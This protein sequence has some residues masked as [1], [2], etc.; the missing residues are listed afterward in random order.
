MPVHDRVVAEAQIFAVKF[1]PTNPE[2]P[3]GIRHRFMPLARAHRV[4]G[5]EPVNRTEPRA[6]DDGEQ[7]MVMRRPGFP[8]L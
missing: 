5:A 3:L 1:D 6:G 2:P 4:A 7:R 8:G